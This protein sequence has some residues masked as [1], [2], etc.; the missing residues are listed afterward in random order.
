MSIRKVPTVVCDGCGTVI[1]ADYHIKLD[2]RDQKVV[3]KDRDGSTQRDFCCEA[4]AEWWHAEF[5]A[6]GAWG[7]AWDE[8]EWW[9]K[10]VRPRKEH[11]HLRTAHEESPLTDTK[12]HFESPEK[13][14]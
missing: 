11:P 7:P 13:T 14:R 10:H 12:V 9:W 4:C 1:D 2:N 6:D 3:Q 5:P 8:R